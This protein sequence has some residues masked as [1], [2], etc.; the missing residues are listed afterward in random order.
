[1]NPAGPF[2]EHLVSWATGKLEMHFGMFHELMGYSTGL[3]VMQRVEAR[4]SLVK[5][6][7][8]F[9]YRQLPA[10]LSATLRRQ[11][12]GDLQTDLFRQNMEAC[13]SDIGQ[14]CQA[15]YRNKAE[16]L[17]R[18]GQESKQS[19]HDPLTDLRQQ[20]ATFNEALASVCSS[21]SGDLEATAVLREHLRTAFERH[22]VYALRGCIEPDKSSIFRVVHMQAGLNTTLQKSSYISTDD[23]KLQI[24]VAGSRFA[25]APVAGCDRR[26]VLTERAS[27]I[28]KR[29][30]NL[31]GSGFGFR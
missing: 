7:L 1:M 12:N 4:H 13:L 21:P 11:Q 2:R 23:P 22:R 9:R 30:C 6:F 15:S 3:C 25:V 20:Q 28:H 10:S 17:T 31:L 29:E 18:L 27:R 5:R 26:Q 19:I 24:T 8:A 16:L 14:L